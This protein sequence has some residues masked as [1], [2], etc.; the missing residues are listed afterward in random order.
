MNGSTRTEEGFTLVELVVAIIIFSL[1]VVPIS[2]AI[3]VGLRAT[4]STAGRLLELRDAQLLSTYLTADAESAT[5]GSG[6]VTS[7]ASLQT[8]D[9]ASP[10]PSGTNVV[11]FT[12]FQTI[13]T[14]TTWYAVDYRAV[15]AGSH[16]RLMRY[17]CSA[18]GSTGSSTQSVAASSTVLMDSYLSASVTAGPPVSITA[19]ATGLYARQSSNQATTFTFTVSATPRTP[20]T[21]T[22][23]TT[24][25]SGSTTSTS[26]GASTTTSTT[27]AAT[28]TT[29]TTTTTTIPP[30]T[31]TE[32]CRL[33]SP[34][35]SANP[36]Y[37]DNSGHLVDS[38]S[39][40][41][42]G[43][44]TC[45]GI[46]MTFTPSSS[47]GLQTMSQSGTSFSTTI[48]KSDYKWSAGTVT[49]TFSATPTG[50]ASYNLQ[51]DNE[52]P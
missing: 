4:P 44:S 48:D 11:R 40:G 23:T 1:I 10:V 39:I 17:G 21:V 14:T 27:T 24:N 12:W 31:T 36:V 41:L 32:P 30:T 28:T 9:C 13:G 3:V 8:W 2:S 45:T 22:T 15:T 29:T 38:L 19:T 43:S 47:Q 50:S 52:S 33:A 5:P 7:G 18:I 42:T 25:P 49:F 26:S 6:T 35:F 51:V 46:S 20:S 16:T 37:V 34:S